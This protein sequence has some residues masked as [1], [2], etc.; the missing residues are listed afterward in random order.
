MPGASGGLKGASD[1][2]GLELQ[3]AV[4]YSVGAGNQSWV[5]KGQPVFSIAQCSH[6]L[7]LR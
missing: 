5:L 4:S 2:M 7:P 1:P 6:Y 3:M